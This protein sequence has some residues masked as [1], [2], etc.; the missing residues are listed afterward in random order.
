M[1]FFRLLQT[2]S[3]FSGYEVFEHVNKLI[4]YSVVFGCVP[5]G[6]SIFRFTNPGY[7]DFYA[8][9]F[10]SIGMSRNYI[11]DLLQLVRFFVPIELFE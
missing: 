1:L 7:L 2:F 5:F 10:V 4:Q 3:N 11:V 8:S 6:Q 9:P